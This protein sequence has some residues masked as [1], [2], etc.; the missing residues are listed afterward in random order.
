MNFDAWDIFGPVTLNRGKAGVYAGYR[1]FY[2]SRGSDQT[3][4]TDKVT[5]R[6]FRE[7]CKRVDQIR[8]GRESRCSWCSQLIAFN[9]GS[10]DL[11]I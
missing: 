7:D 1:V 5:K 9:L 11:W 6:P 8:G 10:H 3:R 4:I 2:G